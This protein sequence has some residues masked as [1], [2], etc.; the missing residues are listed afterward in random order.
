MTTPR[1]DNLA[2]GYVLRE[3]LVALYTISLLALTIA[4]F[5]YVGIH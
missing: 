1:K 2:E 3:H 4:I 5:A